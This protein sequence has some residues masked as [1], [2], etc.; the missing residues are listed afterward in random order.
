[1]FSFILKQLNRNNA[2]SNS[3]SNSP[4]GNPQASIQNGFH[5]EVDAEGVDD[6]PPPPGSGGE[7]DNASSTISPTT[8]TNGSS[9]GI[10]HINGGNLQQTNVGQRLLVSPRPMPRKNGGFMPNNP[11]IQVISY[12]IYH[13]FTV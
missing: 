13:I 11:D 1:M 12:L 3:N 10:P 6:L 9:V 2:T 4:S 8:T 7:D 5:S